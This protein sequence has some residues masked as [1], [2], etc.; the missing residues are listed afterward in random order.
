[1]LARRKTAYAVIAPFMTGIRPLIIVNMRSIFEYSEIKCFT[2]N[3]KQSLLLFQLMRFK[4]RMA[5]FLLVLA[6]QQNLHLPNKY[7]MVSKWQSKESLAEFI[8]ETRNQAHIPEGM[9]K[10]ETMVITS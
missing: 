7:A 6:N 3:L 5:L 2:K 8:C 4:N 10:N 1:M 9:E